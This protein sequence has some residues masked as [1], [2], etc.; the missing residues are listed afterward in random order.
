MGE[1]I[2]HY[3]M[4]QSAGSEDHK[5]SLPPVHELGKM[6]LIVGAFSVASGAVIG[7]LD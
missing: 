3:N 5:W 7:L 2:I 1:A 6:A 4:G